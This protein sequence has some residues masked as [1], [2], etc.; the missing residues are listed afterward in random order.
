VT[1]LLLWQYHSINER[2]Q[3]S[4]INCV[5][6]RISTNKLSPI[7]VA[8]KLSPLQAKPTVLE[9]NLDEVGHG[10]PPSSRVPLEKKKSHDGLRKFSD[11]FKFKF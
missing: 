9:T 4:V 1:T 5:P 8:D 7:T 10:A 11:G 3:I 6:A 2:N